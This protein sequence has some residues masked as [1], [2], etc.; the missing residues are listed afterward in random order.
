MG[1]HLAQIELRLGLAGLGARPEFTDGRRVVG[2]FEGGDAGVADRNARRRGLLGADLPEQQQTE[3]DGEV[4]GVHECSW[5]PD[6]SG[7]VAG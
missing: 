1:V 4:T 7:G 2:P 3:E 5:E 6:G